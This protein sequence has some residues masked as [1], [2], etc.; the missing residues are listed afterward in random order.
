MERSG[1]TRAS[2]LFFAGVLVSGLFF[3]LSCGPVRAAADE[4]EKISVERDK[5]KTSYVIRSSSED[6][7]EKEQ[8]EKAWEMLDHV[9]ID[10]R[11]SNGGKGPDNH[12]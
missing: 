8:R 4:K 1:T 2:A 11:G 6:A 10:T 9:I 3:V 5:E 12:R 7:K